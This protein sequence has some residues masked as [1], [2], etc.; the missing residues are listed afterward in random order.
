[1]TLMHPLGLLGLLAI[2]VL[3]LIYIIKSKYT[4]QV[5]S[6][7][8]LWTLS[9]RF[10]KR[11]NPIKTIT[12]II[13]LILQILAVVL[14]SVA[15]AHPVFIL[16]GRANDYCFILDGSGSMNAVENGTTRFDEAK[17][18]AS[19]IISSAA[20]GST[21]TLIVTGDAA[22]ADMPVKQSE[23]KDF[24]LNQLKN[25]KPSY[26]A[27]NV[28]SATQAAQGIFDE[29]P[30]C[31]FYLFTDKDIAQTENLTVVKIGGEIRNFALDNVSYTFGAGNVKI[32]GNVVC[33][34]GEGTV[35]VQAF[36]DKSETAAVSAEVTLALDQNATDC[37]K[38]FELVWEGEQGLIPTFTELKVAINGSDALAEDDS[39][40]LYNASADQSRKALIVSDKPNFIQT[41]L[42]S[43]SNMQREVMATADYNEDVKGYGLYVF[44]SYSP[45]KMPADG[46]VW[47]VNPE[48][49]VSGSGFSVKGK[50]ELTSATP[51]EKNKSTSKRVA[52]LLKG[53][54]DLQTTFPLV[55]EYVKCGIINTAKFTTLL[56]CNG[57]DPVVFAG[58]N[59]L[60]NR[61]VVFALDSNTSDFFVSYVGVTLMRNLIN[62]TFPMLVGSG[63]S[64]T[65]YCGDTVALNLLTGYDSIRI[66][67]PSGKYQ[68]LTGSTD[69]QL[70]EIGEYTITAI[71]DSS[72]QIEKIY[73]QLPTAER[74]SK[75]E[76]ASF[77]ISGEPGTVKRDGKY[78][79]LLYVFIILAVIVVA[80]WLVYCYE[81][82]QL[83]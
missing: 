31:E 16:K 39:V 80:D 45:A 75:A 48:G 28:N 30:A 67:A 69:Y 29:M 58:E 82:Y 64:S 11:K 44:D 27:R 72:K 7:T 56:Y 79:D 6:S 68:V 42:A 49:S 63:L 65:P 57:K 23:D 66:D 9:E 37:V 33:Y 70:T 4:E 12:G 78:E 71:A 3:I 50:E 22:K 26:A 41:A 43:A 19:R 60:G 35:T 10:L 18:Q 59:N 25:A 76:E 55:L 14:I 46:A 21:Y 13:S 54:G 40:I 2:P 38:S 61:Q 17:A 62:Y 15:L 53:T 51:L 36:A 8:Y 47:F 83:R 73:C 5:I 74:V 24:V 1:M 77:I 81:Q 34:G 32:K 52:E 20:N